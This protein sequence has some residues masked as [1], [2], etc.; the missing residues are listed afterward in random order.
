MDGSAG[1]KALHP[2]LFALFFY[3]L[4]KPPLAVK[5]TPRRWNNP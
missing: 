2:R 1:Q 5:I 4:S 3:N